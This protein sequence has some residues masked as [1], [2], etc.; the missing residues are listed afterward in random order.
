M[1]IEVGD[2]LYIHRSY[3]RYFGWFFKVYSS[4]YYQCFFGEILFSCK[5]NKIKFQGLC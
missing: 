1:M 3:F 2:D 4:T 5:E